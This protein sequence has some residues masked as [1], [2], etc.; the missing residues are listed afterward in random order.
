MNIHTSSTYDNDLKALKTIVSRMGGIAE[1][2]LEAATRALVKLDLEA[3]ARIRARDKE[4]NALERD[5]ELAAI[6][7]IATRAPVADDLRSIVSSLKM[8]TLIERMGDY[9]KNIAKRTIIIAEEGA[10]DIPQIIEEMSAHAGRMIYDVINAYVS[11]DADMAI[12]IWKNDDLLDNMHDASYREIQSLMI[13]RPE[14]INSLTH[15][16]M[17]AKNL[18]RIGD[19]ATNIAE[20]I[21]YAITGKAL[22]DAL[23]NKA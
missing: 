16:I 3:A 10:L 2:Q 14:R 23:P 19:Q 4:L 5:A 22:E 1:E 17:I 7:L 13:E 8:T 21:Y 15:L 20:H 11:M 9:S 18:E 12:T 6:T